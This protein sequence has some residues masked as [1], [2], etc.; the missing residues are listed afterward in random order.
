MQGRIRVTKSFSFDMAHAL[1]GYDGPC[2]NIHGHTYHF[3][4]TLI[5]RPLQN[6][7]SPKNGMVIDFGWIKDIVKATII[8]RF[9]HALV[10]NNG[11]EET[12][13]K[14]IAAVTEKLELLPFQPSC[15]NLLIYFKNLLLP[16]FKER[17]WELFSATLHETETSFAEWYAS[18]N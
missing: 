15:E 8:S 10:L 18:D 16:L 4:V 9:D 3:S 14:G 12:L 7:N 11:I 17:N 13:R 1:L 6:N 5:G 2:R